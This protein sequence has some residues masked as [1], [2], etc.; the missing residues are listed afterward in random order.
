MLEANRGPLDRCSGGI[1]SLAGLEGLAGRPGDART[2]VL[3]KLS[4]RSKRLFTGRLVFAGRLTM[5]ILLERE[6]E[7]PAR[8]GS[9]AG[10]LRRKVHRLM[11]DG[12]DE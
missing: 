12:D 10:R 2:Q 6:R 7:S 1:P 11:G 8:A 9:G 3:R 4:S 5:Y